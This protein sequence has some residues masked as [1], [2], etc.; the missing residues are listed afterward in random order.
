[1]NRYLLFVFFAVGVLSQ[2][3]KIDA[4]LQEVDG[5]FSGLE[6]GLNQAAW[7]YQT[8][9]T[10]ENEEKSTQK[11]LEWNKQMLDFIKNATG[12]EFALY[13]ISHLP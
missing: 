8:N 13:T 3:P 5:V 11:E 12:S 10:K 4:F 1:M 6:Y 2:D 7:E 9:L